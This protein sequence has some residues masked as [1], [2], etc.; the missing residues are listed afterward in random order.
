MIEGIIYETFNN[1]RYYHENEVVEF[2]KAEN[3]F[4]F[5][6]LGKYFSA[7]SN[8]ANLRDKDFAWLVFGVHDKTREILGT[9]YKNGMKSLQKL[10]YDLS[11][12]TT[13]RNTFRDIYELE[14]EGK[15]VLMFQIPAAP[16]G[17]P[18]AWQG[19]FYARR[20]ESLVALDMSKYEEIRR[21]TVNEDW[22]AEVVPDAT[23]DDLDQEAIAKAREGYKQRYPRL[24]KE[25]D[26][27][28]DKVFLDKAGLTIDGKVTRTTLLLVGKETSAHKLNHIAQIVWKCF[29]DG[30]VFG[31]IYTIPFV[32]TTTELLGRIRNYRFKIYPKDSLIPAEVWKY[33]TES[34]LEGMH[35][36]IAHQQYEKNARI[37]VTENMD[38]LKFQNDGNF[39]EGDYKEYITGEKT[40]K[41]YRNPA[42]VKAMVNIRMIDTQGYGI[43]KMYQSQKDRYLPMPD[44]D[45]STAD[46]VVLNLPGTIIDENYSLMLLANQDMSLMDAVL[47]DQVQKGKPINDSAIKKLRKEGLIEGRKPHLYVSKQIAKATNTQVEYTLKKGFN[48]AECQEWILKALKDHKVLSRKQINE[49]LWNKLPMDF[50]EEQKMSKIKNLLYKMHKNDEIWLDEDRMWHRKES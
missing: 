3:N 10:K 22:T 42:L 30:Q 23:I 5:D 11:Q 13:D 8:E 17:I 43:H 36:S 6:D 26:G 38:S 14:V 46:E 48:D 21:Q 34:V 16:R 4:D 7:L 24:A 32:L 44:Y 40:P 15:R 45:L 9:S 37:I 47:L 19:H 39:Y 33:D 1:L 29:Q 28:D 2:K 31:D 12:H 20:G 50:T 49:L 27:W 18:M 25:C 41:S 35:N